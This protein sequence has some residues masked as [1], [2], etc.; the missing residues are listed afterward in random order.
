M[1]NFGWRHTEVL[2]PGYQTDILILV[3][4]FL[5]LYLNHFFFR[6]VNGG[7]QGSIRC[8]RSKK[9][10]VYHSTCRYFYIMFCVCVWINMPA[11]RLDLTLLRVEDQRKLSRRR[12]D[13]ERV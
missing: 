12:D 3:F 4:F 2:G 11:R 8:F 5:K 1:G 9:H 6:G 7:V 13:K 10:H